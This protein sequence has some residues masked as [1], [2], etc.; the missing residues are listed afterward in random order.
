MQVN[1]FS[2]KYP[3]EELSWDHQCALDTIEL[4]QTENTE[5]LKAFKELLSFT[6]AQFKGFSYPPE[7]IAGVIEK[8]KTV[9][10]DAPS[11]N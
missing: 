9:I 5:M 10:A 6:E 3:D 2:N 8:A 11:V 1:E 7:I 4:L